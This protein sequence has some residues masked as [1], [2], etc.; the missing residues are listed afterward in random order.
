[1]PTGRRITWACGMNTEWSIAVT[2]NEFCRALAVKC[3]ELGQSSLEAWPVSLSSVTAELFEANLSRDLKQY[4]V[5]FPTD[6]VGQRVN[7]PILV[8]TPSNPQTTTPI[9]IPTQIPIRA[10]A[11]PTLR[12]ARSL[13]ILTFLTFLSLRIQRSRWMM[14]QVMIA[15]TSA[16]APPAMAAGAAA[17]AAARRPV[18]RP[19]CSWS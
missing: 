10:R 2:D 5:A 7:G 6:K 3:G 12:S 17:L 13:K 4:V 9:L 16:A 1:M 14:A 8:R 15:S 11:I 18:Q 19:S